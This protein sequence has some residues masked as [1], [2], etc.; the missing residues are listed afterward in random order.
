LVSKEETHQTGHDPGQ[1]AAGL[2]RQ[3]Q[4]QE[5]VVDEGKEGADCE[6]YEQQA[7]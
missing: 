4:T 7:I 2:V 3:A 6:K 1:H 5:N